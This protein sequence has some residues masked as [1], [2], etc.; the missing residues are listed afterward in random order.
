[1]PIFVKMSPDLCRYV[2]FAR[3]YPKSPCA[4]TFDMIP[5]R[6]CPAVDCGDEPSCRSRFKIDSDSR[7]G[8]LGI[9]RGLRV[10]AQS[11]I[12]D[13]VSGSRKGIPER[14]EVPGCDQWMPLCEKC[15]I[16]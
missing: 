4:G 10:Y 16:S 14:V 5:L 3:F 2:G 7:S 8:R 6:V 1:M 9:H 11:Y 12:R 13:G 15:F